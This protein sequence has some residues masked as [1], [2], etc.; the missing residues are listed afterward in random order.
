MPSARPVSVKRSDH[1][2]QRPRDA[3]IRHH[4]VPCRE[5]DVLRL[6]VAVQHPGGV[7]VDKGVRHL[8][9]NPQRLG[10]VELDLACQSSPQRLA[11][12]EGHH[13]VQ[14]AAR[15]AGIVE[16]QDVGMLQA[17]GDAG[18]RAGTDRAQGRLPSSGRITFSA[19]AGRA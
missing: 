2:V 5:Q 8:A 11:L 13:V 6:D 4:G 17:A 7:R 15:F 10:N 18:S 12:D 19:T 3:E 9:G 16:A 14:H 1:G